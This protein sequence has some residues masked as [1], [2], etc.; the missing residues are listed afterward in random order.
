MCNE[1]GTGQIQF[2]CVGCLNVTL[3][4]ESLQHG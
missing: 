4:A 3:F 1:A 2:F